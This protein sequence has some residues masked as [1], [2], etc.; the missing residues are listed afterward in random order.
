MLTIPFRRFN[1]DDYRNAP[2]YFYTLLDNL[3][4]IVDTCNFLFQSNID[5]DNNMLA[6]RQIVSC[7][8]GVP[9]S[10][11]MRTLAVTPKLVRYGYASGAQVLA[12]NITGYNADGTVEVTVLFNGAPTTAQTLQL[13][14]EP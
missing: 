2:Q 10:T 3:Q 6:E 13:V 9:F 7:T 8:H 1:K 4:P 11:R 14:F 5:I 12:A